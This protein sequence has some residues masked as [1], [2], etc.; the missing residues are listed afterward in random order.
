MCSGG[1]SK[2]GLDSRAAL[3]RWTS[4]F[5]SA[6]GSA[7]AA[8]LGSDQH[9][10]ACSL[11][12]ARSSPSSTRTALSALGARLAWPTAALSAAWAAAALGPFL[13]ELARQSAA[14]CSAANST[15]SMQ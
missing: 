14:A 5:A 7:T 15:S 8:S 2:R 11:H 1:C 13:P 4:C 12:V 3:A 6:V 9:S 10:T